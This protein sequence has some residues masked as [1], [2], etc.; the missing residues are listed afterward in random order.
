[1]GAVFA[2]K[3]QIPNSKF[4]HFSHFVVPWSPQEFSVNGL[5]RISVGYVYL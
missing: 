1:M 4:V 3:D 2:R 5:D